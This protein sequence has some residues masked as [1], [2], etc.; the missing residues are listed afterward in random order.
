M[1]VLWKQEQGKLL[2][3]ATEKEELKGQRGWEKVWRGV[4]SSLQNSSQEI[5][6]KKK[7]V[8]AW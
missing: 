4:G 2:K 3:A 6:A 7:V 5:Q 8:T 1:W